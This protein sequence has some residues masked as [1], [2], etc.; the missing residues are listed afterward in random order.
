MMKTTAHKRVVHLERTCG[1]PFVIPIGFKPKSDG[2]LFLRAE[3]MIAG[4]A[5]DGLGCGDHPGIQG[6]AKLIKIYKN[7]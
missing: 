7:S 1:C 2:M 4:W 6:P 3:T 5:K